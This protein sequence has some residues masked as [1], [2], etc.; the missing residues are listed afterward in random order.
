MVGRRNLTKAVSR[1]HRFS[2]L[3][4]GSSKSRKM[5]Q[6]PCCIAVIEAVIEAA[7]AATGAASVAANLDVGQTPS[8]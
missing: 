3:F 4:D 1:K 5:L 6:S 8:K 7:I 2:V